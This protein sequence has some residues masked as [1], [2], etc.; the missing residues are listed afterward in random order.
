MLINGFIIVY[1]I[2]YNIFIYIISILLINV[3]IY[4]KI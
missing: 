3:D 4:L 1:R 2:L